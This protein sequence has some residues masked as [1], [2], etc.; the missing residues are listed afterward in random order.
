MSNTEDETKDLSG[1]LCA[2]CKNGGHVIASCPKIKCARC[3][4]KGH[5]SGVCE[6][7][8]E[9]FSCN[10]CKE[11]GHTI[12]TCVKVKCR[13]CKCWGHTDW[14]CEKESCGRCGFRN[15][16][17]DRCFYTDKGIETINKSRVDQKDGKSK[18]N[19]M[20]KIKKEKSFDINSFKDFPS[21]GKV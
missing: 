14:A 8:E 2:F 10:F 15:H 19:V 9:E 17:T 1:K 20:E 18:K 13:N 11:L 7:D 5:V 12:D 21:L 16:K 6:T 3:N 4:I